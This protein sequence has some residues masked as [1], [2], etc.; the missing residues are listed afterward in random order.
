MSPEVAG[1]RIRSGG[2]RKAEAFSSIDMM[3]RGSAEGE[4]GDCVW[5]C[6]RRCV[7]WDMM[8]SHA[9]IVS[10]VRRREEWLSSDRKPWEPVFT[11]R[12]HGARPG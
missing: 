7:K 5:L 9:D 4:V 12:S 3:G 6:E 2:L 8:F 10:G 1:D 11:E